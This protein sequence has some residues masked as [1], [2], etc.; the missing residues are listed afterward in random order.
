MKNIQMEVLRAFVT[1]IEVGGFTQAGEILGRSQPAVSLQ[2]KRL[3]TM[4]GKGLIIRHGHSL[5]LTDAGKLLFDYARRIL[6]LNDEAVSQ[7]S[8]NN[9]A[10]RIHLGIPNEFA[11]TLLPKVLSRFTQTYPNVTLEV[12]SDLSRNLVSPAAR[13]SYNLVLA[14][15]NTAGE[16]DSRLINEDELVW[17]TSANH[18]SHQRSS[19]P[20][21]AAPEGCIYRDRAAKSLTDAG[22]PWKIIYT[23]PDLT[24]IKAAIEGGLGV[25]VLARSTVPSNLKIIRPSER[26]PKLGKIGISLNIL[27]N[28]NLE[29][30]SRLSEYLR[31][32]LATY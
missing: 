7:F 31:A 25:T 17:V 2:I 4:L 22:L 29:A 5:S 26:F 24:G 20:L 32:G 9:I 18:D 8:A 10:G 14:V 16:S 3:E 23:I 15:H 6:Q 19:L 28:E 11:T 30:V 12:T 27:K 21:I 1:V 13:R